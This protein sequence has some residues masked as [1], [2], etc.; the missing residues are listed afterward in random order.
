M[1]HPPRFGEC[2]RRGIP[3]PQVQQVC[4]D[5]RSSLPVAEHVCRSGQLQLLLQPPCQSQHA[6]SAAGSDR[7]AGWL[8][9]LLC[10][11]LFFLQILPV[12]VAVGRASQRRG[13]QRAAT[14]NARA[15]SHRLRRAVECERIPVLRHVGV[16]HATLHVPHRAHL[17]WVDNV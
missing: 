5:V 1:A 14:R 10:T 7:C 17:P 13:E 12:F 15:F 4:G 6:H 8:P 9:A 2:V 16:H 11:R 3:L